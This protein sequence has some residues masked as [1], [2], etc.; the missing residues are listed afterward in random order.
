LWHCKTRHVALKALVEGASKSSNVFVKEFL[1]RL[2]DDVTTPKEVV[3]IN[4]TAT[5]DRGKQVFLTMFITANG[6]DSGVAEAMRSY[7]AETGTAIRSFLEGREVSIGLS[8][9]SQ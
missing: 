3:E 5:K 7:V 8:Q 2:S 9:I 1:G 4:L 6:G